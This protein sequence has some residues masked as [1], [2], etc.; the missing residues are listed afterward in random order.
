MVSTMRYYISLLSLLFCNTQVDCTKYGQNG[1]FFIYNAQDEVAIGAPGIEALGSKDSR[2][3]DDSLVLYLKPSKMYKADG[4]LQQDQLFFMDDNSGSIRS[5]ASN[6]T[7]SI[8]LIQD[9]ALR[10]VAQVSVSLGLE[11]ERQKTTCSLTPVPSNTGDVAIILQLQGNAQKEIL[12]LSTDFVT[13]EP[14]GSIEGI[15]RLQR[16]YQI[17]YVYQRLN[18]AAGA[19]MLSIRSKPISALT[20]SDKVPSQGTRL[21]MDYIPKVI[22]PPKL[23]NIRDAIPDQYL[24]QLWRYDPEEKVIYSHCYPDMVLCRTEANGLDSIKVGLCDRAPSNSAAATNQNWDLD[25]ASLQD[26]LKGSFIRFPKQYT[27]MGT[28]EQVQITLAYVDPLNPES[29]SGLIGQVVNENAKDQETD[30][31]TWFAK[32]VPPQLHVSYD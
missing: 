28:V 17:P 22:P 15:S 11:S 8:Q 2:V 16:W 26:P 24:L 3:R 20:I 9:A 13:A 32:V 12:S 29:N 10:Q 18:S 31:Q 21:V 19:F 23:P 27:S 6:G 1:L 25:L 5:F 30:P 7:R 4:G 14:F